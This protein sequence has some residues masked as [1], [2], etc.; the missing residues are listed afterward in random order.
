MDKKT[1]EIATTMA[2]ITTEVAVDPGITVTTITE[3]EVGTTTKAATAEDGETK[4]RITQ[5][6]AVGT[7]ITKIMEMEAG[8]ILPPIMV[9]TKT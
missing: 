6:G 3:M 1:G 7:T 8:E 5:V 9:I 4:I 2:A